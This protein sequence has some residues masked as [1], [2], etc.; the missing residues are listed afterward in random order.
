[1]SDRR[2]YDNARAAETRLVIDA[3]KN[4]PCVDCGGSFEACVMDFDHVR[5]VKKDDVSRMARYKLSTILEE[6]A[7]CDLVCANCHRIRT[8]IQRPL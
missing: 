6:I 2:E 5:G 4:S 3:L 1:M 8:W 7:K